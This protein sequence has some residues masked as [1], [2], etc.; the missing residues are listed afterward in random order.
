MPRTTIDFGIDLGTTNSAIAVLDGVRATVIK[1]N[2]NSDITPSAVYIDKTNTL[3]VGRPAKQRIEQEPDDA[4]AEFK[5]QMGTSVEY[6]FSKSGRVMKPEDLSA[7]VLK[8]LRTNVQQ[9]LGEEVQA[10]VITVPAAFDLPATK[11]TD[12]AGK[13]AGL[14]LSPLIMEPTAAAMAHSF[15]SNVNN[16]FWLVYDFGGGTFD[17]A[18]IQI[19]DGTFK[20]VNHS[21]DNHLGGKLI[22][23]EIVEKILA[24]ALLK[25]Y[26]LTDF[27]RGNAK[28]RKAFA[29]LKWA[30]EEAKIQ[31]S[32]TNSSSITID[33]LCNDDRGEPVAFEYNLARKEVAHLSEPFIQR[34]VNIARQALAEKRLG[35]ANIQ[36]VVLVG[37]PTLSPYVREH[38]D[39]PNQGLGIPLDFSV[40]PLTVVAQGAAIFAGSQLMEGEKVVIVAPGQLAPYQVELN[41]DPIGADAEPIVGGKV[42]SPNGEDLSR[43]S[44]EFVNPN[45]KPLWRS[46]KVG[47][48][49]NGGFMTTLWAERGKAN[50][51]KI[52]LSDP[53]GSLRPT[54][55]ETV[56]YTMGIGPGS[57][58]LIHS[59]GVGLANNTVLWFSRKGDSLPAR[60]RKERHT[61]V[62]LRQGQ[63]GDLI[64][65]PILEGENERADR[66]RLIGS[67]EILA[68][69]VRRDVPVGSEIEITLDI[70][71]NR[72]V[73]ASAYIPLLDQ[74]FE[75][76]L[77]LEK[78]APDI[79]KLQA[80]FEFEKK[81]LHDV[82][83]KVDEMKDES[84]KRILVQKVDGEEMVEN[85]DVALN[86]A[87]GDRD[88]GDKAQ[89]RLLDLKVV[90]DQVEDVLEWPTL[91]KEAQ[92]QI[93]NSRSIINDYGDA[94]AKS[95]FSQMEAD[96]QRGIQSRDV[97]RVRQLVDELRTMAFQILIS[98]PEFWVAIFQ[99]LQEKRSYM[100][101][102]TQADQLFSQGNQAIESN[103]V[104]RLQAAVRGLLALLPQ[105]QA[106]EVS[107]K[108][109]GIQ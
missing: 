84:A 8:T 80:E 87:S 25:D 98:R 3:T 41:Y 48:S 59:V 36:K 90:I 39:D 66:N 55:P 70:D 105:E 31:L 56:T 47:L 42:V 7:E 23:W 53:T 102:R 37:G 15:Q 104:P 69:D 45:A 89:N 28:W 109:S 18:V 13:I 64:R 82:R 65:V 17:A 79:G 29:K 97:D 10:A 34:T 103:D 4:Y 14:K 108:F 83:Q 46:G 107:S 6:R 30:A 11:A 50:V 12:Q 74:D 93:S 49:A 81:R 24:P 1:N 32:N 68:Q 54:S 62:D 43:F 78:V 26:R 86:A 88:A 61:A 99:N 16:V 73:K 106:N 51:F 9:R 95:R 76:D 71:R 85:I 21:G 38:L 2:D 101:D 22:D 27:Q 58:V 91:V 96:I 92:E 44:I 63:S 100:R 19:R 57:E 5:L 77:K 67:L 94:N 33:Y 40:D 60:Q 20:I 72:L 52:E 75:A 35:F